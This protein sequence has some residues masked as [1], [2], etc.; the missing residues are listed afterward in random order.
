MSFFCNESSWVIVCNR[1]ASVDDHNFAKPRPKVCMQV[2]M[3]TPVAVVSTVWECSKSAKTAHRHLR[4]TIV[5]FKNLH[6]TPVYACEVGTTFKDVQ[7]TMY[8]LSQSLAPL[9]QRT[10]PAHTTWIIS[11]SKKAEKLFKDNMYSIVTIVDRNIIC[12]HSRCMLQM[13]I[14]LLNCHSAMIIQWLLH[15]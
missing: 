6:A 11:I 10:F 14:I 1:V 3:L 12:M 9:Q 7:K 15:C 5:S 8:K 4:H 2:E 13:L